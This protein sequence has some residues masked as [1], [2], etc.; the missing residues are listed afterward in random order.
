MGCTIPAPPPKSRLRTS[1]LI[2]LWLALSALAGWGSYHVA[3]DYALEGLQVDGN[4]RLDLYTASLQ[5]EIDKY[6]FLPGVV[7]LQPQVQSLL[8]VPDDAGLTHYVNHYLETLSQRAGTLSVYL[9]NHSGRVLA[10]SNWQRADSF[11][12]E[13]LSF[14]PYVQQAL[15]QGYGRYFGIGTTRG[16]PGYYLTT[17]LGQGTQRG[18]AVVKVGL[19]LLEHSWAAAESPVFVSDE[20]TVLMLS[21]VPQWRF[22]TLDVLDDAQRARLKS[23][24]KYNQQALQPLNWKVLNSAK[25]ASNSVQLVE[26]PG[27]VNGVDD[28]P[29]Y[30]SGQFLALSRPLAGT[31]WKMTVLLPLSSTLQLAQSR[32]WLTAV[33]VALGLMLLALLLQRRR[34]LREQLAARQA[35]QQAHDALERQVQQRTAQLQNANPALQ[36]EVAARVQAEA[37]LRAAQD[38]LVQAGKLAVIGKLSTEVAHELNQ[39]LAALRALA[40]NSQRFLERSQTDMVQSNLQ[41]MA[42]LSDR[43]G[44]ITGQLRNFARRSLD[45]PQAV[46]LADVMEP[47]LALMQ[48]R[49]DRCGAEVVCDIP[50]QLRVLCDTNRVQ[51]VL[52]NL[53]G[54]ALDAML[55]HSTPRIEICGEVKDGQAHISVRDHGPGLSEQALAHLFQ[56]FFTT[57]LKG[58]GLGLG[59][60]LSS[61]IAKASGGCLQGRNHPEG[62]AVFTLS[63]PLADTQPLL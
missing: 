15:S 52:I 5:R 44:R 45:M 50:A 25:Q 11:V 53:L 30:S 34:H 55:Q 13:N 6:A 19:S 61:D 48:P 29:A 24:L 16:E 35:L 33:M 38:E 1:L 3:R 20:N 32:A 8:Q 31:P 40:G 37:T 21:N 46:P 47:A 62:G 51:Q 27:G 22:S 9:L 7:A 59:L 28:S 4:H 39:P 2:L 41:R 60:S 56:P 57:K 63:L 54:N 18:I 17:T 14:R 10:S 36:Q 58:E 26:L 23:S 42:D 49:M 43:M 12:G